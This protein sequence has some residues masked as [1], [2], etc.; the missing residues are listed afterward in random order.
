MLSGRVEYA[1]AK[2][3]ASAIGRELGVS[4]IGLRLSAAIFCRILLFPRTRLFTA[5]GKALV[6]EGVRQGVRQSVVCW[7]F[8]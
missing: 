7:D 1:F 4:P 5:L 3:S 6:S 8:E 2:D